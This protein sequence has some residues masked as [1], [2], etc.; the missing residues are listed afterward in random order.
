MEGFDLQTKLN[1][2]RK[3]EQWKCQVKQEALE[4][5]PTHIPPYVTQ[6]VTQQAGKQRS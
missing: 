4:V 1:L 5:T 6:Q 2:L 3:N